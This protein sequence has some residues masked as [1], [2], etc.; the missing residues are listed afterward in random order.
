M[1]V[2]QLQAL[3]EK[4]L[5]RSGMTAENVSFVAAS[6]VACE[7]DGVLGHGLLRL[8][9]FVS[10]ISS[11][12]ANGNA[13]PVIASRTAGMIVA[14]AKNGYAQIALA[15]VRAD[16]MEAARLTGAA[17]LLIRNCHHFAALWPDLEPFA[18]EGFVA[19]TCVNSRKR[20]TVWGG[21]RAVIGTN[22]M[23]FACPRM[24]AP[25]MIWDQSSSIQSQGDVLLAANKGR[26]V[27]PGVGCD[28]EGRPT[29]SARQILDG[30]ALLPFGGHKGASLAVMVEVLAGA[31]SGAAFGFED[32]AEG[33]STR[34]SVGGQFLL[35]VDP[36][37]AGE[38]FAD[39]ITALFDGLA[40]AGTTRVPGERRHAHRRESMET[41]VPLS[42]AQYSALLALAGEIAS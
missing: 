7:R 30:G 41:G 34:S 9:G 40:A 28:S 20:M 15:K 33:S 25:P 8:P 10:D 12:W 16:L 42:H 2:A 35:V 11:G 5:S 13:K 19:F 27:E 22:A 21:Q 31:L 38:H 37:V 1:P 4:A 17:I 23:A 3:V 39:R 26:E 18:E 29:T 14:D 32:E 6:I 36:S 24:N